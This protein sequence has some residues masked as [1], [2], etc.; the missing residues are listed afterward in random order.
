MCWAGVSQ[1][2]SR[3]G[4]SLILTIVC[5]AIAL[6]GDGAFIAPSGRNW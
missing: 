6:R 1:A 3:F 4:G 2:D 5:G